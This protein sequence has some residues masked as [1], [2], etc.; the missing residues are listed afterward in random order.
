[1]ATAQRAALSAGHELG[2]SE[3]KPLSE[4]GPWQSLSAHLKV[5]ACSHAG[6]VLEVRAWDI[7]VERKWKFVNCP[8][9]AAR[10]AALI[11]D[12]F[13]RTSGPRSTTTDD[14]SD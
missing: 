8:F 11:R 4:L 14:E 12:P 7:D 13:G 10:R 6:C 9:S 5:A 3:A 1:M 2:R